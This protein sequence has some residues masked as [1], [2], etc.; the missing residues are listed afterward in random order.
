MDEC[1]FRKI[2]PDNK[3]AFC[4]K[5]GTQCLEYMNQDCTVKYG[6]DIVIDE[7]IDLR[8]KFKELTLKTFSKLDEILED[9]LKSRDIINI[10]QGLKCLYEICDLE[11]EDGLSD[12]EITK[13]E[14]SKIQRVLGRSAKKNKKKN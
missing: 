14:I 3:F 12:K 8:D 1:K 13:E 10:G 11:S 5:R 2:R 9:K 7:E 6:T 4:Q